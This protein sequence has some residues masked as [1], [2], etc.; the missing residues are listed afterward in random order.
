M[1]DHQKC[2]WR[3][4]DPMYTQKLVTEQRWKNYTYINVYDS[5]IGGTFGIISACSVLLKLKS[6]KKHTKNIISVSIETAQGRHQVSF[7]HFECLVW[8]FLLQPSWIS[9]VQQRVNHLK[10]KLSESLGS[11]HFHKDHNKFA[12]Q[13]HVQGKDWKQ[14]YPE[15]KN[16]DGWCVCM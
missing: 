11:D 1:Y 4:A 2:L 13:I 12:N 3:Q 8:A 14:I 10:K 9:S 15:Q 16:S 6:I 7:S 5:L